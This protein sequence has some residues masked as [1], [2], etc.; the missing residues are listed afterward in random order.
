MVPKNSKLIFKKLAQL[1]PEAECA[2]Y[3]KNAL[4]LLVAT[5]LSAQCTDERV[6]KITP[7]LFRNY[8]DVAAFADAQ[9]PELESAIHSAGFFRQ[10]A[11]W[12]KTAC[13]RIQEN[14][15]GAVP[16]TM[17]ELLTLPGVARKTA[18][19]VLGTAYGISVGVVVDTHVK[20]LSK[21][22]GLTR[23]EDPVKVEQ[24]LLRIVP[25][26]KWIWISHALIMHG[27]KV[28]KAARPLCKNCPLNQICP[29]VKIN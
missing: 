13:L 2:L 27:R 19:V 3:H 1:Y 17:E 11:R 5:I 7:E 14:F 9:L 8:P 23:Q 15:K 22:L 6:N 26:E 10:K 21:R 20:R 29:S 12:I 16:S 4:Q 24:D 18:N 28:C 25:K